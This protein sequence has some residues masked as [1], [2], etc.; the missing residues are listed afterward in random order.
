MGVMLSAG[1]ALD[2]ARGFLA[3]G[4][5]WP[6]LEAEMAQAPPGGDGLLFLPYLQGERTPHRDPDARG[7]LLGLSSMT[8]RARILR[9][10]MEGVAFGLRDCFELLKTRTTVKRILLVGGGA[11]NP[12]WRR[13][14]SANLHA[15]VALPAVDEGGAY[16][17]A[18]LAALGAGVPLAD[19]KAWAR[20]GPETTSDPAEVERYDALHEQFRG[21]YRDLAFRFKTVAAL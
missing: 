19:L 9:A 17:A 6:A 15:P 5:P 16:G 11:K 1:A 14:L 10:V 20:P 2:Q 4:V 12:L 21:L 13:I 8:D 3:P 18:M 7:V